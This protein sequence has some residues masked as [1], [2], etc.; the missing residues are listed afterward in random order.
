M[1]L[2]I[3]KAPSFQHQSQITDQVTPGKC[4]RLS[5]FNLMVWHKVQTRSSDS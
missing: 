2:C 1:H 5:F 4:Q 3:R